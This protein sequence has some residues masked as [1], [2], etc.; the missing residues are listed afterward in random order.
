MAVLQHV[1]LTFHTLCRIAPTA[2]RN[3]ET[4]VVRGAV[5]MDKRLEKRHKRQV[6]RAR[7][8]VKVS[9]PD[10]RT[11][12]QIQA[13][14]EAGHTYGDHRHGELPPYAA[15]VRHATAE[16]PDEPGTPE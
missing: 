15:P 5:I 16:A 1:S 4:L 6:M 14:R 10:L 11:P 8:K 3:S 9:E 12:E 13:A 7:E 2:R